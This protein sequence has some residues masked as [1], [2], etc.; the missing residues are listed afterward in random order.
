MREE[1]R[2]AEQ[3]F[4]NFQNLDEVRRAKAE[5]HRFGH[6]FYRFPNGEA[7][8]D[9]YSRA[10][11]FI[12]TMFRHVSGMAASR[13]NA[14]KDHNI[15]VITHGLTLRLILMRYFQLRVRATP[16]LYSGP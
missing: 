5:R 15:V 12:N 1:P 16:S 14:L 2:I 8:M 3:Q 13:P 10:T 6:F 9:V 4:G 11:S 7:G